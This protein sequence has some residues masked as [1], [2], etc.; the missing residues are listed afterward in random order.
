MGIVFEIVFR[1][2]ENENYILDLSRI[3]QMY[4]RI[5]LC[6]VGIDRSIF[7]KWLLKRKFLS[8]KVG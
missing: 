7:T 8:V 2:Y 6:L 3:S 1:L 4:C 5:L